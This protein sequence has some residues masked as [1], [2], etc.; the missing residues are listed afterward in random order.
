VPRRVR[1]GERR[2]VARCSTARL[3]TAGVARRS[4]GGA[5]R[6]GSG[7]IASKS[8]ST[9]DPASFLKMYVAP[10]LRCDG[11]GRLRAVRVRARRRTA[12]GCH[13]ADADKR[14]R[15]DSAQADGASAIE[16]LGGTV[17]KPAA[18]QVLGGHSSAILRKHS[19]GTQGYS[20][21][22]K[23]T[24]PCS[25]ATAAGTPTRAG[26]NRGYHCLQLS[27]RKWSTDAAFSTTTCAPRNIERTLVMQPRAYAIRQRA[28][29]MQTFGTP[30]AFP[31][32]R[33]VAC[34]CPV[35]S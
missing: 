23:G 10:S 17:L 14:H 24:L 12:G 30:T 32:H 3:S 31:V 5:G 35:V 19:S 26:R 6:G 4:R 21:V 33:R 25:R 11:V 8:C 7:W 9:S 34:G 1:A 28:L 22:P 15:S 2:A 16:A 18:P 27:C 20:A 29:A 13:S